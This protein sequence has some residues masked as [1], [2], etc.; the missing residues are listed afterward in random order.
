MNTVSESMLG[1]A[2]RQIRDLL[3]RRDR[4]ARQQQ[5]LAGYPQRIVLAPNQRVPAEFAARSGDG[6][7]S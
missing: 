7:A 2:Y 1:V 4:R 5:A 6:G 3:E